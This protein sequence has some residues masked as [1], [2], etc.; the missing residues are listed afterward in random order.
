[1][2]YRR[3]DVDGGTF[4]FTVRYIPTQCVGTKIHFCHRAHGG[5]REINRKSS[6]SSV[7]SVANL[8]S[9]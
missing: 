9:A 5:H 2:R 6:V 3:S 1:M 7:S 8:F 4:F